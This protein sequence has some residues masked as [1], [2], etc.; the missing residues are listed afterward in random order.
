VTPLHVDRF[1]RDGRG[2]E[3]Q[4]IHWSPNGSAILA[5]DY[6]NPDDVY[7]PPS[8]KH[9]VFTRAQVVMIT[10]EE[11]IDYSAQDPEMS[12]HRTAGIFDLGRTPWLRSFAPYHL[13]RCHHFRLFF[14]DELV[15]VVAES[16]DCRL[17]GFN[18]AG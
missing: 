1:V 7:K 8:L 17:G 13:E 10:P 15:D 5:I 11:V 12:N 2:P 9:V 3:L 18:P 4:F 6:F 14:Y 16:V